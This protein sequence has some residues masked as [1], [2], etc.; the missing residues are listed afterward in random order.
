MSGNHYAIE[1]DN[2]TPRGRIGIVMN[3][4]VPKFFTA[5]MGIAGHSLSDKAGPIL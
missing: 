4:R 5:L 2:V 1:D 3:M